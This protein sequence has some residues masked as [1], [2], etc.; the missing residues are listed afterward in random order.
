[1]PL[2]CRPVGAALPHWSGPAE[3]LGTLAEPG[4][5]DGRFQLAD[6]TICRRLIHADG[7]V[8]A[9]E[10]EHL[11]TG[12]MHTV[13]T[14]AVVLACDALRTPQLLYASGIR[15]RALGRYL[16]DQPQI[17]SALVLDQGLEGLVDT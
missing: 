16:N 13:S 8:T 2:A 12:T 11:P 6:E 14:R 7:V 9:V 4:P 3:L 15:P 5:G 10:L 1:M 17:T